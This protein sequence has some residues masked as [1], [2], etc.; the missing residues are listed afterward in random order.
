[1]LIR[2]SF[3]CIFL[4]VWQLSYTQ[5]FVW[6]KVY[7]SEQMDG[8]NGLIS[9]GSGKC[10]YTFSN[11]LSRKTKGNAKL[12]INDSVLYSNKTSTDWL[13]KFDT[14]G[15]MIWGKSVFSPGHAKIISDEKD[16]IY[17]LFSIYSPI[18][19]D[20]FQIV[21]N[22]KF[23]KIDS[24]VNVTFIAKLNSNGE[25]IW[26]NQIKNVG[27]VGNINLI[28][29]N[30]YFFVRNRINKSFEFLNDTIRGDYSII[31][32]DT[33]GFFSNFFNFGNNKNNFQPNPVIFKTNDSIIVHGL[34]YSFPF[35]IDNQTIN[36]VS[37]YTNFIK[38]T[39][40]ENNKLNVI[41]QLLTKLNSN[42]D[43]SIT[44]VLRFNEN[45]FLYAGEFRDSITFSNNK[46]LISGRNLV[47]FL[48]TTYNN[49][50]RSNFQ[51][52]ASLQG[53]S[54][55]F[56]NGNSF[57][58][59]AY[60]NGAITGNFNY[61]DKISKRREGLNIFCKFD[62]LSNMLWYL[63][64]GDS[65]KF[66]SPI[67]FAFDKFN[68]VYFG[69]SFEES[70]KLDNRFYLSDTVDKRDF[71]ISKLYDFS[72]TR[73]SVSKGP[74]CAGDT[75]L[76]PY[77]KDGNFQAQNEFIA[78]LSDENG[79]FEGNHRELGRLQS[80][81]DSTIKGI[82]PLFDV[83][84][85]AKYRI[86]IISTHP[87]VQ[88]YYRYDSLRLLIFSKDTANAGMDTNVCYGSKLQLKTSG[89]SLWRWSPGN[90]VADSTKRITTTL[91]IKM[92]VRFRII[93]SDSSGCGKT[94]TAYKWVRPGAPLHI[95]NS[96]S[97][98]CFGNSQHWMR[99]SGGKGFGYKYQWLDM[100]NRLLS[101]S[102]L[103]VYQG[104]ENNIKMVLSD[105]CSINDT[106]ILKLQFFDTLKI[107]T[108]IMQTICESLPFSVKASAKGG[109]SDFDFR[110][111][112]NAVLISATDSVSI[113]GFGQKTYKLLITDKLCKN[114]KD[115]QTISITAYE[116]LAFNLP[117]DTSI[118]NE[119]SFG[120]SP[121]I[122][123]GARNGLFWFYTENGLGKDS[124]QGISYS[125]SLSQKSTVKVKAYN[126]CSQAVFR[127][128]EV[129]VTKPIVFRGVEDT[130]LCA[131][132][133]FNLKATTIGGIN[134]KIRW[135]TDQGGIIKSAF[136][137]DTVF[138]PAQN[139]VLFFD[140]EDRCAL[141]QTKTEMRIRIAAPLSA[142][143]AANPLCFKDTVS[144]LAAPLGGKPSGYQ[145]T[146]RNNLGQ[147]IGTEKALL[148]SSKNKSQFVYFQLSDPCSSSF[149][150]SVFV[151]P[152]TI[153]STAVNQNTQCFANQN[154][155]FL[156]RSKKSNLT[157]F[158]WKFDKQFSPNMQI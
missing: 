57:N 136:F 107:T 35:K 63:R 6:N 55:S 103:L 48:F 130:L 26:H 75:F 10:F 148:F 79:D 116:K 90:M 84:T 142:T 144:L 53:F 15:K 45:R 13:V 132:Q 66:F 133:S 36:N 47:P 9:S 94:D 43:F 16:C 153:A 87:T 158:L 137:I 24:G 85:S 83:A 71:I 31:K 67:G 92:P 109:S 114:N 17:L 122:T 5:N 3:L 76:I 120:F 22:S 89:G 108:P 150:D 97:L 33:S 25:L 127:Q 88:S 64:T 49:L 145:I 124:F 146:W 34:T 73:G 147:N 143:L 123:N 99:G 40:N 32:M 19:N 81:K 42:R 119:F 105:G 50:F 58:G 111:W 18:K 125:K 86:R 128:M 12:K 152:Q 41:I 157:Q 110:W 91:P 51:F 151:Q 82:L 23:L 11:S 80:N 93:I 1:M 135:K 102:Q 28:N 38:I 20:T 77:T 27:M 30:L 37:G 59:F 115:S 155:S 62:S 138:L 104:A 131:G 126:L 106:Q 117:K 14:S 29:K 4:S 8:L 141:A 100:Q 52:N 68:G 113:I 154:F 21:E 118:C 74:Y 65:V 101:D 39:I 60:L 69:S 129:D 96:H 95:S 56:Y 2:V 134:P 78:E 98:V 149:V 54:G 140:A 46:K 139:Q 70:I 156:N 61:F 72:I 121:N 44:T 112:Q 7:G